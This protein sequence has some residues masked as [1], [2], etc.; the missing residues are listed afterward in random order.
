MNSRHPTRATLKRSVAAVST[1]V[2]CCRSLA[3]VEAPSGEHPARLDQDRDG[4]AV[5]RE[6]RIKDDELCRV[7]ARCAVRM[8]R[9]DAGTGG[10]VAECP[11]VEEI[12]SIRVVGI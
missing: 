8:R 2:E 12:V 11:L 6:C 9:V 3:F 4:R 1:S 5:R 7:E 10:T